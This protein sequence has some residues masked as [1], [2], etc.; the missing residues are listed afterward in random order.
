MKRNQMSDKIEIIHK[1]SNELKLEKKPNLLVAELLDTELIGEGCLLDYHD[2]NK[3]LVDNDACLFVP[4]RAR[5]YVQLVQSENLFSFHQFNNSF[6]VGGNKI[7][8]PDSMANCFGSHILHDIQLNQLK[9]DQ[10]FEILSVPKIAFEFD[11][12]KML[13]T[14]K[15]TE[16]KRISFQLLKSFDKPVMI[17]SW[18]EVDMD[19]EGEIVLSCGPYWARG[20]HSADQVAWRDHWMQTVYFLPA[21]AFKDSDLEGFEHGKINE[22]KT[23]TVDAFHD[24]F[25][26]WFDLSP[27]E[28]PPPLDPNNELWCCT[29]R[30]HSQLSRNRLHVINDNSRLE[31]Y[32]NALQKIHQKTKNQKWKLVYLGDESCLPLLIATNSNVESVTIVCRPKKQAFFAKFLA[33]NESIQNKIIFESKTNALPVQLFDGI[34]SEMFF[35]NFQYLFPSLEYFYRLEQCRKALKPGHFSLPNKIVIR[36][37]LVEFKDF[38]R[39]FADVGDQQSMVEGFDL[40]D[41]NELIQSAR[42]SVDWSV[43]PQQLWE[44]SNQSLL[45]R[46]VDLFKF[47]LHRSDYCRQGF[48]KTISFDLSHLATNEDPKWAEKV[49]ITVWSDQVLDK[50][51][52]LVVT[53]GPKKPVK[54][55]EKV[56][57][58]CGTQQGVGFL[59][60]TWPTIINNGKLKLEFTVDFTKRSLSFQF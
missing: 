31:A 55:G 5:V 3:R 47:D 51:E 16:C 25:S 38:W 7:F 8:I 12:G 45:A 33:K 50:E 32:W 17:F 20:F 46:P 34:I 14:S 27:Q 54:V 37:L 24:S 15:F 57:W 29:C 19:F 18:W 13:D 35:E 30:H 6:S 39:S 28:D 53:N 52:D 21:F 22:R 49:A 9:V 41:Y 23:F 36:A 58:T 48:K 1:R 43:E 44:Y 2:A 26:F 59:G 11:F 40:S 10:D 56:E 60:K 42:K 4:A